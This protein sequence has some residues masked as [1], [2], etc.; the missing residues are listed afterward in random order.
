MPLRLTGVLDDR[1]ELRAM[2]PNFAKFKTWLFWRGC[3]EGH[4]QWGVVWER[5]WE[6]LAMCES[7][8][9]I[10]KIVHKNS[11][12]FWTTPLCSSKWTRHQHTLSPEGH[13]PQCSCEARWSHHIG[14]PPFPIRSSGLRTALKS[15]RKHQGSPMVVAIVLRSCHSEFLS[16]N[17]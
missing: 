9:L 14:R 11:Y 2:A 8:T 15:P 12:Q 1:S 17:L 10:P 4:P 6:V 3:L 16:C 13:N 5:S 7:H